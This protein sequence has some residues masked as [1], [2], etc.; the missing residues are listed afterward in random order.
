[1]S[2][3]ERV[4]DRKPME[5]AFAVDSAALSGHSNGERMKKYKQYSAADHAY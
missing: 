3:F 1:M 4:P 2:D 5:K